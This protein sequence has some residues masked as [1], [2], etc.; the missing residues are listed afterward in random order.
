MIK[1]ISEHMT[2]GEG[3]RDKWCEIFMNGI[4]FLGSQIRIDEGCNNTRNFVFFFPSKVLSW[5]EYHC[6]VMKYSCSET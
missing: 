3:K 6:V 1:N 4:T 2:V 5:Y